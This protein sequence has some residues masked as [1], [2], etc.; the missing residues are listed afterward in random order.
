[1]DF[2]HKRHAVTGG[3]RPPEL[4]A[5][6]WT[7]FFIFEKGWNLIEKNNFLTKNVNFMA[8]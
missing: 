2:A 3:L 1:M 6:F 4:P 7:F 5:E 8:A